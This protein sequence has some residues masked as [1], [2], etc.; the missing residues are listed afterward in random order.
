[1]FSE[2]FGCHFHL[3]LHIMSDKAEF[4]ERCIVYSVTGET[5]SSPAPTAPPAGR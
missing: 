5:S 3:I 4:G 2:N 1:M